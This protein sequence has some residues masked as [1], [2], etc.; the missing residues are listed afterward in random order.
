MPNVSTAVSQIQSQTVKGIHTRSLVHV[1][2]T[3]WYCVALQT[4][5]ETQSRSDVILGAL[6]WYSKGVHMLRLA[7]KALEVTVGNVET[8][9]S[10]P[11]T[12]RLRQTTF[13]VGVDA[14]TCI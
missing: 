3:D 9:W 8:N 12:D 7:H 5:Y 10:T 11:Q 4:V 14:A 2:S 6:A 13:D 1:T